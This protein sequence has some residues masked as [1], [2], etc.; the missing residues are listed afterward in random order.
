[1]V[2]WRPSRA[3]GSLIELL[4][5]RVALPGRDRQKLWVS[6]EGRGVEALGFGV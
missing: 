6:V 4:N 1:M 5:T 2:L 3:H